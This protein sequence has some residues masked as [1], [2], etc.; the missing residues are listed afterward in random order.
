M[1]VR[2]VSN[3]V[4]TI[5]AFG[6]ARLVLRVIIYERGSLNEKYTVLL[7]YDLPPRPSSSSMTSLGVL[8]GVAR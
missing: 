6:R 8:V 5:I 1:Y 4:L 7:T 3:T 2:V